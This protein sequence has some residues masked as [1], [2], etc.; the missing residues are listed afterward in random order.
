MTVKRSLNIAEEISK[1]VLNREVLTGVQKKALFLL[2][3]I[4]Q[5][6]YNGILWRLGSD[7]VAIYQLFTEESGLTPYKFSLPISSD[8]N[9]FDVEW[10]RYVKQTKLDLNEIRFA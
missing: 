6:Y 2:L 7:P 9:P 4:T 3:T 1:S 10:A 8:R 5:A